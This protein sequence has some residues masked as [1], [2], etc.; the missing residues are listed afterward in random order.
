MPDEVKRIFLPEIVPEAGEDTEAV[1]DHRAQDDTGHPQ[2][3][4]QYDRTD[5]VPADL[6]SIADIIA[7]LVSVTVNHLFNTKPQ[8]IT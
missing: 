2:E 6:E 5:H 4:G 1:S 7:Q 3:F 8:Q